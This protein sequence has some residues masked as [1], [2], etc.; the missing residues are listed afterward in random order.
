MGDV[1]PMLIAYACIGVVSAVIQLVS[2]A[3]SS[4]YI[5]QISRKRLR[6]KQQ[7]WV[8]RNQLEGVVPDFKF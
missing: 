6:E 4:A 5:A 1:L 7:S 3:A 8:C 2:V